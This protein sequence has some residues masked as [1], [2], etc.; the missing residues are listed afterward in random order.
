M[1]GPQRSLQLVDFGSLTSRDAV[2]LGV[3]DEHDGQRQ[4]E[5]RRRR[6][7]G[8]DAVDEQ[9]ARRTVLVQSHVPLAVAV[10]DEP[11]GVDGDERD[12]RTARPDAGD[13]RQ[14]PASRHPAAVRQ[15]LGDGEVAVDGDDAEVED[16]RRTAGDVARDPEV[17]ERPAERPAAV[18]FVQHGVRHD[19]QGHGEV[20]YGQRHD[21]VVGDGRAEATRRRDGDDDETVADQCEQN[22]EAQRQPGRRQAPQRLRHDLLRDGHRR[23]IVHQTHVHRRPQRR[24]RHRGRSVDTTQSINV[25]WSHNAVNNQQ[26]RR[27]TNGRLKT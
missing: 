11:P 13:G 22:H 25:T 21:E 1:S 2:D 20:G 10:F 23:H 14:R 4:V 12:G 24:H 8:I 27:R 7:D 16:R 6:D 17:T 9:A 18:D 5:G 19:Q 15:R 3:E 26:S